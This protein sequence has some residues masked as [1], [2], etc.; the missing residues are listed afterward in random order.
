MTG[1]ANETRRQVEALLHAGHSDRSIHQATG[2]ARTTI[3]RYR[4]RLDIPSYLV[5]A[6]SPAC[7]HGHPFPENVAHYPTGWLYCRACARHRSRTWFA[8]NY[9][10][11]EPDEAAIERAA[12]GDPP[13]RL[14][15]RERRAAIRQL[16]AWQLPASVIAERVS[17]S[18]RTVH[19]ARSR[20]QAA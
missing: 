18:P 3:A 16:D 1:L 20:Q 6:D 9:V 2:V 4:K 17:C 8:D 13:K 10:P 12:A 5:T 11:A 15:P 7:R 14:T 19:R